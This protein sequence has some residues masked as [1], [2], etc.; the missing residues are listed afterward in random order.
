[1]ININTG[2]NTN[3]H[4]KLLNKIYKSRHLY[5]M[6]LLPLAYFIIFHYLPMYGIIIAFKDYNPVKGIIG[7]PWVGL[8]HFESFLKDVR[9]PQLFRNTVAIGGI[10]YLFTAWPNI[11]LALVLNEFANKLFRKSVLTVL[12]VPYYLSLV[13]ICGITINILSPYGLVNNLLRLIGVNRIFFL[14]R[15]GWFIPIYMLTH[16]W[17]SLGFGS[18]I[19]L[20]L[21][22]GVSI[23]LYENADIEGANRFQKMW[24]I[25]IPHILPLFAISMILNVANII[26]PSFE[27]I[28]LLYTPATYEVADVISTYVYRRGLA[29]GEFSYGAAIGFFNSILSLLF[30]LL[31]N[32][33]VRKVNKGLA[34]F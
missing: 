23:E 13:I 27:K 9:M 19:Y 22:A 21:L 8:K 20:A 34:L 30:I 29:G 3:R 32:L 14:S 1:M 18:L 24:Y 33:L 11:I 5:A 16:F 31:S 10:T 26:G 17:Q 6:L 2:S 4:K 12:N 25:S 15:P 7:S 28:F